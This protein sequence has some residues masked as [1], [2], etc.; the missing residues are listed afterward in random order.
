MYKEQN[1]FNRYE[2]NT[3]YISVIFISKM[4]ILTKSSWTKSEAN[5][6]TIKHFR[7]FKRLLV[8]YNVR[9]LERKNQKQPVKKVTNLRML[10]NNNEGLTTKKYR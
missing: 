10:S 1:V 5:G 2:Y 4:I 8:Y 3:V 7:K 6:K 9:V